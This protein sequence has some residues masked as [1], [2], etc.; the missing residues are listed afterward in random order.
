MRKIY[1][2]T[3]RSRTDTDT[4]NGILRDWQHFANR[5]CQSKQT[6]PTHAEYL[7]LT[8][9]QQTEIKDV[10]GYVAG[11]Y[12][13]GKRKGNLLDFR[14]CLTLDLDH[15]DSGTPERIRLVLG[16]Y[17]WCLTSTHKSGSG[18]LR[19]RL[20]I[21]LVRDVTPDEYEPVAR[22]VAK[23]IGIDLFDDTTFERSR[24]MFWSSHSSDSIPY[25]Q[26]NQANR[27]V[28]PDKA[29][30]KYTDWKD[31]TEW[32]FSSRKQRTRHEGAGAVQD[33]RAKSGLIGAFCRAHSIRDV[34][35]EFIPEA[36][37]DAGHDRFTYIGATTANGAKLYDDDT[38]LWSH[39]ESDPIFG[40]NCNAYDL[41]RIHKFVHGKG[42]SD[43]ESVHAMMKLIRDD[44]ASHKEEKQSIMGAFEETGGHIP[45]D[46]DDPNV[47]GKDSKKKK[48]S[49]KQ[50]NS[51]KKLTRK[52]TSRYVF[53]AEGDQVCDL[54]MPPSNC[55]R[56]L[57]EWNHKMAGVQIWMKGARGP[58]PMSSIWLRHPQRLSAEYLRFDPSTTERLVADENRVIT[59]N[60]FHMPF[61]SPTTERDKLAVFF[62][63][64]LYL[65]PIRRELNWF[66]NWMA[67]NLQHPELRCKITPL[68]ISRKQGTG[69]G[70]IVELMSK[71][72]GAWNCKKTKI[73]SMMGGPSKTVFH[74]AFVDSL[75]CAI[76][77]VKEAG[78]RFAVN[79]H[80]KDLLEAETLELNIKF[81]KQGTRKVYT[82]LFMQSNHTDAL[83]LEERD[84][85][86]N[87]FTG[88]E[89]PRSAQYYIKL[90]DW[91]KD[92]EGIRQ[93][94]AYL[95][96]RDL[97]EFRKIV[98]A[99]DTPGM[100]DMIQNSQTSTE[101]AFMDWLRDSPPNYAT[102][103]QIIS[104]VSQHAGHTRDVRHDQL[105]KLI[106][107]HCHRIDQERIRIHGQRRYVWRIKKGT[108]D[109]VNVIRDTVEELETG[110]VTSV[111]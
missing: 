83:V 90:Y 76:D 100:R 78:N 66:V 103:E 52:F 85:R 19:F 72:L 3:V 86:I 61:Y 8:P 101:A 105:T 11:R 56:K 21:P 23:Q 25:S 17:A 108:D 31:I 102:Q 30:A 47:D 1:V 60:T 106:Q 50:K 43:E 29:L 73:E 57:T 68:H 55:M 97:T 38:L 46:D 67:F 35:R 27:W 93:L 79:D 16:S 104:M 54:K 14:S 7:A 28:S 53:V 9:A 39:H 99:L 63:H 2:C 88:P 95:M 49:G 12:N 80:I 87:V 42:M 62:D 45:D 75:F 18:A 59:V 98:R 81:G 65:F 64:M 70:W 44:A 69:R 41:V 111:L 58:T 22:M 36:Y 40:M 77:E 13:D 26:I 96:R 109:S 110:G 10:G 74:D 89:E 37:E 84:R 32:T 20:V 51:V 48:A 24:I 82:N 33:P 107:K 6:G 91:L 71:L 92:D 4:R 5:L 34:M 15:A 94:H